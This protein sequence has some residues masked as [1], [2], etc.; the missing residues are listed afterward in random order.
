MIQFSLDISNSQSGFIEMI[1]DQDVQVYNK[2]YQ[3]VF[4]VILILSKQR[5]KGVLSL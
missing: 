1:F 4:G 5:V 2:F 3:T